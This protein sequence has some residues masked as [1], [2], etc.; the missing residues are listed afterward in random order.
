M[1]RRATWF[2]IAALAVLIS[3]AV[4]CAGSA[5][6]DLPAP[7][8]VGA[9][10][11]GAATS[12]SE[13][14]ADGA[15]AVGPGLVD[16]DGSVAFVHNGSTL[17]AD[18]VGEAVAAY[19]AF[20][21][22]TDAYRLHTEADSGGLTA[23]AA[24]DVVETVMAERGIELAAEA[25]VDMQLLDRRSR[26]NVV[27]VVGDTGAL[28]LHDCV[29]VE[30]D[31]D[32][33]GP[34]TTTTTFVDQI[35]TLGH[36]GTGWLVTDIDVRHTG[37]VGAPGLGC[38]PDRHVSRL[39]GLTEGFFD[40]MVALGRDPDGGVPTSVLSLLPEDQ[41][42]A[43]EADVA[44]QRDAGIVFTDPVTY[45]Y[46]VL[47]SA[48]T[49]GDRSFVVAVCATYPDGWYAR[50]ADTGE[51]VDEAF[52]PGVR[53]YHEL[54]ITSLPDGAGGYTDTIVDAVNPGPSC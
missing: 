23:L 53:Y 11:D 18:A 34:V 45:T 48:P 32:V 26:A 28:L 2:R 19:Q 4:A 30:S 1:T 3:T 38:V 44:A 13:A 51:P 36:A 8:D 35:V 12:V 22:A 31:T 50:S 42:A 16:P 7:A 14:T 41:H 27:N 9:E 6:G 17:D 46:D 33:W 21:T 5:D 39:V 10:G 43:A 25:E 47:G 20:L 52:A 15:L 40:A 37:Q 24:P 29:E 54:V 49:Y